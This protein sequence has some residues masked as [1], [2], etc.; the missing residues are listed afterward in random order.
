MLIDDYVAALHR[1]LAGPSG[2][3]RDLV[4]EARDSLVDTA[5]AYEAGGL[6]RPEAERLAVAEFGELREVAPGYQRELTATAGRRL[7]ALLFVSVPLTTLMWSLVW[8]F[9]P[10]HAA[11]WANRPAW[12]LTVARTLDVFH[13]ATGV[14]GGL[15]LLALTRGARWVR[16]PERV[17]RILALWVWA[18]LPV[19]LLL[20]AALQ[21]GSRG[22]AGFSAFLPGVIL[23]LTTPVLNGLQLYGAAHCL[24]LTRRTRPA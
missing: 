8:A 11:D 14:L 20:S 6:A 18:M 5:E 12:F 24:R 2:A 10:V 1:A 4:L 16:G 15:A 17:T 21:Y 7:G 22:P 23:S 13:L 9:F 3:K 19:T